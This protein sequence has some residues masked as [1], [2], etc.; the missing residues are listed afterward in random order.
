MNKDKIL[1]FPLGSTNRTITCDA[2]G[3]PPPQIWWEKDGQVLTPKQTTTA[4]LE[5]TIIN[6][7][8]LGSYLCRARNPDKPPSETI[9]AEFWIQETKVTPVSVGLSVGLPI[10]FI[11]IV[12]GVLYYLHTRFRK[13]V[14]ILDFFLFIPEIFKNVKK[15][16]SY[17]I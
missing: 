16:L 6:E 7:N 13:E 10:V 1:D 15:I 17:F 8:S 2:K 3:S 11:V 9:T 14:R 4:K 5:L 12:I